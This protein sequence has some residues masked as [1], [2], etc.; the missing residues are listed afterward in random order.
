MTLTSVLHV[1]N[2]VANLLSIVH[3]TIE[4]NCRVISSFYYCFF[5]D[6]ATRK[7]IGSGSLKD[8]LY[9]LDSQPDAHSPLIQAYHIV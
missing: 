2:L 7:M 1:P 6:L 9:Y 8:G 3:I 5:Q 4:L